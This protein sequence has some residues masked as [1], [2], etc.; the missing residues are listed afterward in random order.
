MGNREGMYTCQYTPNCKTINFKM[1]MRWD[2]DTDKY[3]IGNPCRS[4]YDYKN[5]CTYIQLDFRQLCLKKTS[6]KNFM[7]FFLSI[8]VQ[9]ASF[10]E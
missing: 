7:H 1:S 3:N 4:T 8:R 2:W 10:T 5:Q 6:L 9:K